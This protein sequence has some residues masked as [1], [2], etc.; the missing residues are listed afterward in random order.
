MAR[1]LIVTPA[2]PG[3]R[4]GNRETAGRWAAMLRSAGHRVS[5]ANDWDGERCDL[6]VALHAHYSHPA[7][8]RYRDARPD[9]PLV[10]ALTGTDLYRDLPAGSRLARESLDLADRIIVLQSEA[11]RGLKEAWRRKTQVVYQS[12]ATKLRHAPPARPFRIAVVGHLRKVK[13][14]FRAAMALRHLDGDYQVVQIGGAL[15][16]K[17]APVARAW[18]QREPRY[19][20][21][22]SLPHAQALA[23]IARSHVL[24]VSSEMEGGANVIAEAAR[25]GT[26]VIAS[27]MAGNRGMLGKNYPGYYPLFNEKALARLIKRLGDGPLGA[28]L[29]RA[30]KA[31]RKQFSPA[32]E[33]AALLRATRF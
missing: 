15:D 20:W 17:M 7:L 6:L 23:W 10:V 28:R 32:A 18:Q 9:G 24:V 22:G 30:I 26:P 29:A 4:T 12:S 13:D 11:K 31:R 19:R 27:R 25:I 3:S 2:R 8:R 33:R 14:P 16:P 1:I 21:T 5:V